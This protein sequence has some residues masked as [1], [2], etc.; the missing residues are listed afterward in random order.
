MEE[1][2]DGNIYKGDFKNGLKYGNGVYKWSDG[3]SYDGEWA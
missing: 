1:W 3:S 2:G